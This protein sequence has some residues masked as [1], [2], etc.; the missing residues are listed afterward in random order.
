M[1]RRTRSVVDTHGLGVEDCATTAAG[2]LLG[3][4]SDRLRLADA[5]RRRLEA[6]NLQAGPRILDET[7]GQAQGLVSTLVRQAGHGTRV[8]TTAPEGNDAATPPEP[9]IEHPRRV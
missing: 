3:N 7:I 6:A 1:G 9:A 2:P 8:S 4:A 5:E